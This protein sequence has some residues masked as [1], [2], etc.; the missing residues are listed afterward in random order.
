MHTAGRMY[1]HTVIF[2]VPEGRKIV[3]GKYCLRDG[4]IYSPSTIFRPQEE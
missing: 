3:L 1:R 4:H 2:S